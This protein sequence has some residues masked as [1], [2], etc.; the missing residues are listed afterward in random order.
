MLGTTCELGDE[1][2]KKLIASVTIV[3]S[4]RRE[5]LMLFM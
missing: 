4:V 5:Q 3:Y 2:R 1:P